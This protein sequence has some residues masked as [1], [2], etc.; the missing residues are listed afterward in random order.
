M[1]SQSELEATRAQCELAA[2]GADAA[3]CTAAA[4]CRP[5]AWSGPIGP[6]FSELFAGRTP[7]EPAALMERIL[8]IRRQAVDDEAV[9]V[10][11]AEDALAAAA[12][13]RQNGRGGRRDLDRRQRRPFAA[14]AGVHTSRVRLQ[15][16]HRRIRFSRGGPHNHS[17]SP[18]R[19]AHRAG[20]TGRHA[21]GVRMER[22][23]GGTAGWGHRAD[24]QPAAATVAESAHLGPAAAKRR[25]D[26]CS[27]ARQL[28]GGGADAC[29]AAGKL[30][31]KRAHSCAAA[32]IRCEAMPSSPP[33]SSL[34][35]VDP[36]RSS[37]VVRQ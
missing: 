16:Q 12:D 30:P 25:A 9:A 5:S 20:A 10:Q 2:A 27:A 32:R 18:H 21:V 3:Q 11:A 23:A 33:K 24:C 7:P 31:A 26:P 13:D 34:V 22:S 37:A 1:L 6:A 19:H 28:E 4:A 35:P 29:S 14:A 17:A 15:P 36:P 8:P